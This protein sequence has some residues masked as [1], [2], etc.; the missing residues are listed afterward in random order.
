MLVPS[1]VVIGRGEDGHPPRPTIPEW[2]SLSAVRAPR[3]A[4]RLFWRDWP[5]PSAGLRGLVASDRFRRRSRAQ[6]CRWLLLRCPFFIEV[7]ASP[8]CAPGFV[9]LVETGSPP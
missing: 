6:R 8:A 3:S 7:R 9:S 2:I 1:F 5:A 4:S